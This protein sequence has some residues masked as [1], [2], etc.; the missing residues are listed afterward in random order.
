MNP[1]ILK[2]EESQ[3]QRNR[4]AATEV[5]T[6]I[7][8]LKER[9][10][11]QPRLMSVEQAVI[12]TESYRD[13][14]DDP[15]VLQR[16]RAL[17]RALRQ[18]GIRMDPDELI[19][20]NRTADVRAGVVFPEA[21]ISWVGDELE[22]LPTRLQDP[23]DV[24]P[25]D[26][27]TFREEIAPFW[28]GKTLENILAERHGSEINAVKK[29]VKINQ[30]DHA[31]GHI[32][33]NT[34]A[35]LHTGPAGLK[36]RATEQLERAD[37]D[38]QPF[39]EAVIITLDGMQSFMRRYAALARELAVA[40]ANDGTAIGVVNE[41]RAAGLMEIARICE[42]IADAPPKTFHEALQS[43][44]F[45]F[46]G[47]QMESNASSFSPGR[48]DQYLEPFLTRDLAD[49]RLSLQEAQELLDALWLKFNQIIYMRNASSAQYFAGFPIGFNIAVGGINRDGSD[50]TNLLSFM[51]LKS[52]EHIGLPQP[53]LSARLWTG[54]P[55]AFVDECARIIGLGSGMPQIVSDE[56][57]IP[58]LCSQGIAEGDARDYAV[59]GCVE[60][61]T[62][63]NELGWSDAAM[64]NLVKALELTLNDGAC[65]LTGDQL[66]PH[67]GTLID[68]RTLEDFEAA[69]QRQI[70]YF[71]DK[72]IP[73]CDAVDRLHAEVLPSP[74]LSTVIDDC[75]ATGIDV[76]A[77]GAHYNLSGIQAIQVANVAD[78]LAALKALVFDAPVVT[79]RKLL[80]A[81][82]HDFEG[83]EALR[84]TLLQQAPKYGNDVQWV[85]E[86]GER[87]AR[88]FA[89]RLTEFTNARGGVYHMGLYTV[90][91]HV[92]MGNNVGATPDGRKARAPLADGGMSAVYGRDKSGPTALLQ[93]VSRVNSRHASNGTLLNMKFLPRTFRNAEERGKFVS[94]L[95]AFV[96]MGIHH[97]QFNVVDHKTL[98][99]AK[100]NPEEYG[101]LTIRVAGYTAYFVELAPDLQDEIIARTAYGA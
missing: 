55:D 10:Q 83:S 31:Q 76:T 21:G 66:G 82:R 2:G 54:S 96:G 79:P 5:T 48:L 74:F 84:Q 33:P 68:F 27:R 6:R 61:S 85:D 40:A 34:A 38:H 15:R 93:S 97:V 87:W 42:A 73:L 49:S 86:F 39:Y 29:V 8:A 22:T 94:L 60:L 13:H 24:R 12:I 98:L 50:A 56:S 69:F 7:A 51:C 23:F 72:M 52:Q 99:M 47:L 53:N 89:N 43:V 58:S 19:V 92:P 45:L 3:S 46:V 64:F 1:A 80:E 63:G 41:A 9:M 70:D 17:E 100:E 67:T 44:W 77:G 20:G 30:T 88:H 62:Q 14:P 81:L 75:L 36:E 101:N 35:W 11:A 32:C 16:A 57:V 28:T 59:V 91:A 90:S 95:R 25:G 71:M 37:A 4:V 26:A 18:I 78:S 65:L